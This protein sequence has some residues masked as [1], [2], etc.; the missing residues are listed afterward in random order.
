MRKMIAPLL[1]AITPLASFTPAHAAPAAVQAASAE[2]PAYDHLYD[3][4]I[5]GADYDQIV[6]GMLVAMRQAFLAEKIIADAE[7]QRPGLVDRLMVAIRPVLATYSLRV[8]GEY[9]PRMI[10][11]LRQHLTPA[12]AAEIADFYETPIGRRLLAGVA[13]NYRPTN[14]MSKATNVDSIDTRD[15]TADMD[16]TAGKALGSLTSEELAQLAE[17]ARTHP[18]IAK[19]GGIRA[20]LA[21]L[22]VTMEKE[23]MTA[24]EEAA[25]R[26]AVLTTLRAKD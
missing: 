2:D 8:R 10:G 24:E 23:P 1:L 9:R 20:D 4:I 7:A 11:L 14:T 18:A 3:A 16:Q 19:L 22:R 26:D 17:A 25:L 21:A 5:G 12:E 13:Q 6:D 15:V